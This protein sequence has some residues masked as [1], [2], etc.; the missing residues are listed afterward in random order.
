MATSSLGTTTDPALDTTL[1]KPPTI[2]VPAPAP[3]PAPAPR[4][5]DSLLRSQPIYPASSGVFKASKKL[6]R[7]RVVELTRHY[8]DAEIERIKA[9]RPVFT[10]AQALDMSH[11]KPSDV[12][13]YSSDAELQARVKAYAHATEA[14]E[15]SISDAAQEYIAEGIHELD[16]MTAADV[17]TFT[18]RPA[19]PLLQFSRT[20]AK[21]YM[22]LY[23]AYVL[24]QMD[25]NIPMLSN[26]A[27]QLKGIGFETEEIIELQP[28]SEQIL[29]KINNFK[30]YLL[31]A[32]GKQFSE[33][34]KSLNDAGIAK[35][36]KFMKILFSKG[37]RN[38]F[39]IDPATASQEE[40]L[41]FD[42]IAEF[43]TI[44][45]SEQKQ[46]DRMYFM[47]TNFAL[48]KPHD[49]IPK[50]DDVANLSTTQ[51]ATFEKRLRME[52][53][54]RIGGD[55][56]THQISPGTLG[57]N[58]L[59]YIRTVEEAEEFGPRVGSTHPGAEFRAEMYLA[60][61]SN[62][63]ANT[64]MQHEDFIEFANTYLAA[65]DKG[66]R[67]DKKYIT[68]MNARG[69]GKLDYLPPVFRYGAYAALNGELRKPV[70][71]RKKKA[72]KHGHL[73]PTVGQLR[74]KS[75]SKHANFRYRF[76][77]RES[78]NLFAHDDPHK[79][80][81]VPLVSGIYYFDLYK[82]SEVPHYK[83]EMGAAAK[84]YAQV[85][86]EIHQ[87]VLAGI[88][89]T[90][91]QSMSMAMLVGLGAD[92]PD[93]TDERAKD[94]ED[95]KLAY[96]AFM[97]PNRDHSV[98]EVMTSSKTYG[99]T[100]HPGPGYEDQ[101]YTNDPD[102]VAKVKKHQATRKEADGTT[103]LKMPI[104]YLRPTEVAEASTDAP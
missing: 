57:Q 43:K 2:P 3:P 69:D 28:C 84:T 42:A 54:H 72:E 91:D 63:F 49:V 24:W 18:Q 56:T 27:G 101:V 39:V 29:A 6:D 71:D 86:E 36:D 26:A 31:N 45:A 25:R 81:K 78:L 34:G 30:L 97:L 92:R 74:T 104:D 55:G 1:P 16:S 7:R 79:D 68:A 59:S 64:V 83:P 11:T 85:A 4:I 33:D 46:L 41:L 21:R 47:L 5:P 19:G 13:T 20:L 50:L 67:L 61:M 37:D 96:L 8:G 17:E 82:P 93:D 66:W 89:G 65:E 10:S 90:Y 38:S 58:P 102:F 12:A 76:S 103:A 9:L 77:R 94:L 53:R 60:Y 70:A 51:S 44:G 40:R 98:H 23:K 80:T 73:I 35:V 15:M 88:S 52:M 14:L 32:P 99:L 22:D 100:Y 62:H 75:A 48:C 87:P 95:I